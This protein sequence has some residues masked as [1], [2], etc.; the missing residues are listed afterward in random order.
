MNIKK[1]LDLFGLRDIEARLYEELFRGGIMAAS[2]LARRV[3]ISR[4]SIYDLSERL[5]EVGLVAET[6]QGGTKKFIVQPPEKIQLLIAEKE[7]VLSDA[8][9]A[10][11]ELQKTYDQKSVSAKPRLQ[12]F[13][14]RAELQQMM[15]DL[16]LYRNIV[17]RAY[18]P[19]KK[20]LSLLSPEFL[21]EFH[22][23]RAARNITLRVI[24]PATQLSALKTNQFLNEN[25]ELKREARVA[26]HDVDFSLGYSIYKNTVRFISSSN[27]SFGFLVESFELAEMMQTQYDILWKN[28]K[29][30]M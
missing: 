6:L 28:S 11:L 1:L 10:A 14:G 5:I 30:L 12:L 9:R 18:W 17:V 16:L 21:I 8:K 24:W 4:T 13:E 25:I 22:K 29:P 27:E 26:P 20:M 2:E 3:G 23:E 19:V 7:K 15:K